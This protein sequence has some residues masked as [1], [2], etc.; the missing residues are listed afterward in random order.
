MPHSRRLMQAKK[1]RQDI[2]S[3]SRRKGGVPGTLSKLMF[4]KTSSA[5]RLVNF[6]LP[7]RPGNGIQAGKHNGVPGSHGAL[8][9]NFFKLAPGLRVF[10][11]SERAL[12]LQCP[13]LLSHEGRTI[14]S[15]VDDHPEY[16]LPAD[17]ILNS[18]VNCPCCA[19]INPPGFD[20]SD[21]ADRFA[22]MAL[23]IATTAPAGGG[24]CASIIPQLCQME[25]F[26]E[27]SWLER[28]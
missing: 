2:R 12:R 17:F 16:D 6:G 26:H 3:P 23:F 18:P 8:N 1:Q 5:A 24:V 13:F 19:T 25:E 21:C 7:S 15:S 9:F 11:G 28:H 22:A 14:V 20:T 27:R 4:G 10:C